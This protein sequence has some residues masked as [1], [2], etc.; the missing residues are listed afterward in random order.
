MEYTNI[1][2]Q[3][4][5]KSLFQILM[6]IGMYLGI[7]LLLIS[8]IVLY[9]NIDEIKTDPISYGIAQKGFESCSCIGGDGLIYHYDSFSPV[10]TKRDAFN[11]SDFELD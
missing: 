1:K 10:P 6:V 8:I 7:I 2:T 9:K 11:W 5:K 3:K 4:I